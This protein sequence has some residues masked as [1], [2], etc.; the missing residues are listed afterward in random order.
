MDGKATTSKSGKGWDGECGVGDLY[1]TELKA[2]VGHSMQML[3]QVVREIND[4]W[5]EI[6]EPRED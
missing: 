3:E 6:L 5:E 1:D 2:A 4:L